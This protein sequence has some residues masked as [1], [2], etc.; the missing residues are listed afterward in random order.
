MCAVDFQH[1]NVEY[2]KTRVC[3]AIAVQ[4]LS[5]AF[6]GGIVHGVGELV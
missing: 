5:S 3:V 1:Q 2:C 4:L 6:H